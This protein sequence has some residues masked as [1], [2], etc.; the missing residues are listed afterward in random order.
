MP[1][2]GALVSVLSCSGGSAGNTTIIPPTYTIGGT[3]SGLA[4]TGLVL[5]N[6]AG[7]N[8][9]VIADETSF[10]FTISVAS[11]GAYDV[12]VLTQPS[13][14]AQNC[15]VTDGSGA[16]KANVNNVVVA[17]STTSSNI[18]GTV[19]GLAGTGL[20]LQDNGGDNL[21]ITTNGSFQFGTAI[22]DGSAYSVTV[23]TEPLNPAQ[24]CDVTAGSG[25][26]NAN[27]T[28]IQVD[29]VYSSASSN[30]WTWE[31]GPDITYQQGVYGTQGVGAPGNVPSA[32]YWSVNWIDT[33]GDF[34]LFGGYENTEGQQARSGDMNDLWKYNAGEW[35]WMSGSTIPDQVG[36]YG[37]QGTSAPDNVPGARHS[38]VSWTDAVGN[39]WLFGGYGYD[40]VGTYG[41]LDD[42][43][44]YSA[45]QWTW[46]SGSNVA[47][48]S[49][50]YGTLG[51]AAPSNMPGA[52]AYAVSFVDP[53]GDMWLFGGYGYD[54]VGTYAY[55][56]DL[57]KYSAGQWTWVSGSNL[58]DQFGVYG[59]LG[60]SASGNVP[61]SRYTA[62]GW[63]DASG[64]LWLF[65]GAGFAS[66]GAGGGGGLLND[67]WRYRAGEWTWISGSNEFNQA[68]TYGT[69]GTPGAGNT[70]GSRQWPITWSDAAGNLWLFGG[71]GLDFDG[72]NAPLN[73]LWRYSAGEWTWIG[74]SKLA[75]QAGTYGTLGVASPGNIAGSRGG[76]A[77]WIDAS[78]NFWLFGGNSKGG[79]FNDLWRYEP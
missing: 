45:G 21:A 7:N 55:L 28:N 36:T 46:M 13:N 75:N 1:I 47:N 41:P 69:Q 71:S 16:A 39:F 58:A 37:T 6:N 27:V 20:V 77:A 35:T 4:G 62:V 11:S 5:Q 34:W 24:T 74:G 33:A 8:L 42:L 79:D 40:S 17:C 56:N 54:S 9:T 10:T 61:G 31:G 72:T 2:L 70:P 14:P 53:A 26:A 23:L 59:T 22:S 44:K 43:W 18:G 78:G 3:I 67:L 73:D 49:G 19:S 76:A 52:R 29:C 60:I 57:W 64:N 50:T 63:S 51:T 68:G 65:G 15:V 38:A 32:R 48:Q 25:M 12:T 66:S 30:E